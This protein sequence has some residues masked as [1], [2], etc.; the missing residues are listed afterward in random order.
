[1]DQFYAHWGGNS[2]VAEPN[3]AS[4]ANCVVATNAYKEYYY[5]NGTSSLSDRQTPAQYIAQAGQ[6]VWAW[7]KVRRAALGRPY[8]T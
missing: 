5:Y 4:T 8:W 7:Q 6:N 1:M 3:T 2:T